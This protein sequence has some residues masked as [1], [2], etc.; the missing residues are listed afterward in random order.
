MNRH[1]R[2]RRTALA[3]AL[4]LA[5]ASE[6]PATLI[7]VTSNADSGAGT[8]RAALQFVQTES[9]CGCIGNPYTINFAFSGLTTIPVNTTLP[10]STCQTY[11]DG[12]DQTPVPATGATFNSIADIRSGTNAQLKIVLDGSVMTGGSGLVIGGANSVVQG[13][14]FRNFPQ[15][16]L[17]IQAPSAFVAGNFFGTNETASACAAS[18]N[19]IGVTVGFG[20]TGTL[21]GGNSGNPADRNVFGCMSRGIDVQASDAGIFNNL[22]GS[23][24]AGGTAL[25]NGIGVAVLTSGFGPGIDI[26]LGSAGL[27]NLIAR[28]TGAGVAIGSNRN[29]VFIQGND[30]FLNGGLGI[31]LG[32]NGPTPNVASPTPNP[33]AP[34]GGQNFPLVTFVRYDASSTTISTSLNGFANDIAQVDYYA[35]P[36][37]LG[38]DEGARFIGTAGA[39]TDPSGN[40][41]ISP[42]FA[43]TFP[44]ITATATSSLSG[45]GT[46]EFSPPASLDVNPKFLTFNGV[47][48]ST[49]APQTVTFTNIG[50]TPIT[51]GPP[52]TLGDFAATASGCDGTTSIPPNGTCTASVTYTPLFVGG[53][54]DYLDM[55]TSGAGGGRGIALNGTAVPNPVLAVTPPGPVSFGSQLVGA[56]SS[57]VTFTVSNSGNDV[58]DVVSVTAA[59]PSAS[60]FSIV[61]NTCANATV[62]VPATAPIQ[63]PPSG[64]PMAAAGAPVLTCDIAVVMTPQAV[65]A[66][67][68]TLDIQ[69]TATNPIVQVALNGTGTSTVTPTGTVVPSNPGPIDFGPRRVGT[70]SPSQAITFTN[71]GSGPFIVSS[72]TIRGTGFVKTADTCTGVPVGVSAPS[73]AITLVFSPGFEGTYRTSLQ[74]LS[75]A[76]N[77][78]VLIDLVGTG[79]APPAGTLTASPGGVSFGTQAV[80]VATNPQTVQI[81]NGGT[82]PV[83][84]SAVLITGDF[85]QTNDCRALDPGQSC[86]AFV[87]FKPTAEGDRTGNLVVESDASNRQLVVSLSGSGSPAP[88]P[89]VEL[90]P[91]AVSFGTTLMGSGGGGTLITLRNAGGASLEL[92]RIYSLGDFRITHNC[93]PSVPPGGSCGVTVSFAPSITGPRTG[94]LVVES[95]APAGNKEA[96]LSGTG[97]RNFGLGTSRLAQPIC[98]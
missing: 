65:G 24:S 80:G 66:L 23:A 82:L 32:N 7:T 9:A 52:I 56:T 49:T 4:A 27:G 55:P 98:K 43:G 39:T 19:M 20:G 8:L 71:S 97:C 11:V 3:G 57:P 81:T 5:F 35:N 17:A 46:S 79:T 48:G 70:Q 26:G 1:S 69:S 94:K 76:S 89:V 51:I 31:D 47:L 84:V 61:G 87:T 25:P 36:P 21:V 68:A 33:G 18:A 42:V 10:S 77:P 44:S 96:S 75:D 63:P 2:I 62:G 92:G 74:I 37:G 60:S 41:S 90:N 59:G 12:Y 78:Q 15:T 88:I 28:N 22:I 13:L 50:T 40:L 93:L 86:R 14:V 95:N 54:F 38:L 30:I 91:G 85:A 72:A 67:A 16:A 6:A 53:S 83:Q 58:F 29:S 45:T 73:C 34:N 64:P